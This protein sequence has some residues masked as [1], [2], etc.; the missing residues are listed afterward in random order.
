MNKL[1][2]FNSDPNTNYIILEKEL[3]ESHRESFPVR[4]VKFNGKAWMIL[5][6]LRYIIV[7]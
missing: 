2:L 4:T 1:D 7:V 5:G 3:K 6:I